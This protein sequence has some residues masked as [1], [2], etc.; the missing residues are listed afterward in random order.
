[1]NA[2]ESLKE[3]LSASEKKTHELEEELDQCEEECEDLG[4]KVHSFGNDLLD[5]SAFY[6]SYTSMI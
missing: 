4:E 6:P 1:M 3:E 2:I 5:K